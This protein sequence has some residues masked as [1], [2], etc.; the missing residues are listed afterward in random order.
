MHH[1]AETIDITRCPASAAADDSPEWCILVHAGA[2]LPS[3]AQDSKEPQRNHHAEGEKALSTYT[4]RAARRVHTARNIFSRTSI[5]KRKTKKRIFSGGVLS[6]RR[7]AQHMK[8]IGRTMS[9]VKRGLA[10]RL[11]RLE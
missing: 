5:A 1:R 6:F 10:G 9:A 11:G 8:S 7:A 2:H 3:P 4:G